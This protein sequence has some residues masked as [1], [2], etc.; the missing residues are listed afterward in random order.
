MK[1]TKYLAILAAA[2]M[3]GSC[4]DD[5]LD[6]EPSENASEDQIKDLLDKDPTAIQAYITGYYKN[7]FSPEAQQSHDDFGLKAFELATDLMGD[8]M[9][10]MTSHFFVYDYLLDNRASSYRRT[11]TYW[12][13]LYAV[14]SG[15]NEVI[16]GLK[17]QADSGDESVE[18]MLGQSYT[19]RAYCY[20]WLINMYQQPY[21]WNKDKLGIPIYTES[22]TKLN[23]VPV[24]EVYEQILSDID[25]GYNYLKGKGIAKKDELNE[26]AAAAIY[27]N[28][29]SFVNDYP[30][31]WN[32]VAK[33]AKLAIEGGSLMSEKELLSGFNDLSLSEVLWGADINGETNTFYASFMSQ[34]DPYGPG[35][36]GNLGNYK[37]ISSDLYEKI[38][39]NDIRKKWFGVDLGEANTHYKVRQYVQRKFI[40]VGSTAP[41]FTPTGDT[42]CSDYIYLRTGEMY[43][44][45]AEALYRAGKENE[46]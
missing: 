38:S 39:D 22:E 31:Q 19:I 15:A 30:D 11:T 36:G 2:F 43:F 41:G 34:V 28:I 40:D 12:Q 10:Y 3:M 13:E 18:K 37:M 4:S 45:A 23:R 17:E 24:G 7:M 42:F 46:A 16:S 5:F 29:L 20:F 25:K 1:Y 32:E 26:Y 44:V 6:K 8:D 27:A 9:A 21:E 35:Y 33:Y 14:I